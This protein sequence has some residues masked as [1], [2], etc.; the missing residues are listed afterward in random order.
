MHLNYFTYKRDE[1]TCPKCDWAG[2]GADLA[3]DDYS[4]E[5]QIMDLACLPAGER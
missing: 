1:V 3:I 5:H 4:E 2:K